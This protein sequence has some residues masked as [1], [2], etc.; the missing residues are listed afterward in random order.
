[1]THHK[2]KK[3]TANRRCS[4]PVK[5]GAVAENPPKEKL[6]LEGVVQVGG[7]VEKGKK[8]KTFLQKR[9][10]V[11]APFRSINRIKNHPFQGRGALL[12]IVA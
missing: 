2:K 10:R 5:G 1:V 9:K 4:F 6:A 7:G 3:G 11:P 8:G 12:G